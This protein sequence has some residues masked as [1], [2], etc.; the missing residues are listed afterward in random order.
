MPGKFDFA[1]H[2]AS[3]ITWI[4]D[5]PA[6]QPNENNE[7]VG[8]VWFCVVERNGFYLLGYDS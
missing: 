8:Y 6:C 7:Y 4:T 3:V 1:H 2:Y 5:L